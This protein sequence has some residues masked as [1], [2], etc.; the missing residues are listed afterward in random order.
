[1]FNRSS[2]ASLSN[3]VKMNGDQWMLRSKKDSTKGSIHN[4]GAIFRLLQPCDS[5]IGGKSWNLGI[6]QWKPFFMVTIHFHCISGA[7]LHLLLCSTDKRSSRSKDTRPWW[8]W[9]NDEE[10]VHIWWN[11]AF[12]ELSV[13]TLGQHSYVISCGQCNYNDQINNLVLVEFEFIIKST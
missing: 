1:M 5:F 13:T 6:F 12:M 10:N 3:S 11:I 7:A 4:S 9:E 2:K 8:R